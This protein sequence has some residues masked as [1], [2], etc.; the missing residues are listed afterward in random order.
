M[1]EPSLRTGVIGTGSMGTNHVRVHQELPETDLVGIFDDNEARMQRVASEYETT[2]RTFDE[3]LNRVDAMSI[4]V[5]TEHH[6]HT[7]RAC[8]DAGV[9][10]LVEKPF[11]DSVRKGR[12]LIEFAEAN[13]VV[14]QVGHIE[15][16]NPAVIE[17]L[18]LC[19]DLDIVSIDA[20]RLS[21]PPNRQ[22]DESVVLDLMIHDIDIMLQLLDDPV[23]INAMGTE[24][25]EYATATVSSASGEIGRLTAS[26]VTQEK[27]RTLGISAT[28]ARV[29]V[30]FINQSI[31]ICRQSA[32]EYI[33][34]DGTVNYRHETI[35][36][37]LVV[38]HREPLKNQITAFAEA[39]RNNTE[40]VVTGED[41]LRAVQIAQR[42]EGLV[43]VPRES[44]AVLPTP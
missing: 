27:V 31:D 37:N 40:P 1:N 26:R 14:L 43:D 29:T 12:S 32:P 17:L 25:G 21:P 4:A 38:E 35:V 11:V 41:G 2:T 42:I 23:D 15:R 24:D 30:D 39:V 9:H 3:L 22:I 20:Q 18:S 16:F 19:N 36:E 6:Y 8:I 7:V 34:D 5:P 44:E 33:R 13:D 28:D 10:V